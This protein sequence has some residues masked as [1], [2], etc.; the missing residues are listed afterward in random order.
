[1]C[2]YSLD[3]KYRALNDLSSEVETCLTSFNSDTIPRFLRMRYF[4]GRRLYCKPFPVSNLR[5]WR[6]KFIRSSLSGRLNCECK[7]VK[8]IFERNNRVFLSLFFKVLLFIKKKKKIIVFSIA[9]LFVEI[10][11]VASVK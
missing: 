11:I 3:P 7:P 10:C 9:L 1:M 5:Y 2:T 8:K 6:M 4:W